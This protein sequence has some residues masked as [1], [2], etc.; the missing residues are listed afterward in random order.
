[1]FCQYTPGSGSLTVTAGWL[2]LVMMMMMMR[3]RCTTQL[4]LPGRENNCCVNSIDRVKKDSSLMHIRWSPT[5]PSRYHRNT[6][7]LSCAFRFP[8][9]VT[10]MHLLCLCAVVCLT[11]SASE[12]QYNKIQHQMNN[13]GRHVCR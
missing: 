8:R 12:G 2:L 6:S 10:A 5:F 13:G 11:R 3:R 4:I 9:P 7:H 1:M